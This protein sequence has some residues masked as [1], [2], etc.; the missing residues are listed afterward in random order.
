MVKNG[1]GKVAWRNSGRCSSSRSCVLLRFDPHM[2]PYSMLMI[3]ECSI[4]G[5]LYWTGGYIP[6]RVPP[7]LFFVFTKNAHLSPPCTTRRSLYIKSELANRRVV[8]RDCV[9]TSTMK[10]C[11]LRASPPSLFRI[12]RPLYVTQ[13]PIRPNH[14]QI[15][16]IGTF[17]VFRNCLESKNT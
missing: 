17:L 4:V 2:I 10:T 15:L 5:C 13:E 1:N 7:K 3:L 6:C 11:R 8:E 16:P 14:Q 12:S 9:A